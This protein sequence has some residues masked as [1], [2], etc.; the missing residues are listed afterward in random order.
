MLLRPSLLSHSCGKDDQR[1]A[2]GR[3]QR[4]KREEVCVCVLLKCSVGTD[5]ELA[6]DSPIDPQFL[7]YVFSGMETRLIYS[8]LLLNLSLL[9]WV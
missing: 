1:A 3:R 7:N 4:E 9:D 8:I 5:L 2:E 6:A